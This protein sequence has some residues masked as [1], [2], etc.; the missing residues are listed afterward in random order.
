LSCLC[1]FDAIAWVRFA[2][3]GFDASDPTEPDGRIWPSPTADGSVAAEVRSG[4][5]LCSSDC[6]L[7]VGP[8]LVGGVL[9]ATCSASLESIRSNLCSDVTY[10][11]D[12]VEDALSGEGDRSRA[13]CIPLGVAVLCNRTSTGQT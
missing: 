2:P 6:T 10:M 3:R 4:D 7:G 12:C 11:L 9:D 1:T 5:V 8:S 13:I